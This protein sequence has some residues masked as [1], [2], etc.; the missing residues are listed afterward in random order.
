MVSEEILSAIRKYAI[1]NAIDYGK[2]NDKS[3]FG[4]ILSQFPETK[5]EMRELNFEIA[6]IVS[7]VN[8][9]DKSALEKEFSGHK[10]EFE[11]AHKKKGR[12]IGPEVRTRRRGSRTVRNKIPP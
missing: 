12:G 6:K 10:E 7:E 3:V 4:K 8:S 2:A 5:S 11:E 1:K 9:M